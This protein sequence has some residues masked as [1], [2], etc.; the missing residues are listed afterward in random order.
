MTRSRSSAL[1]TL[2]YRLTARISRR[3]QRMRTSASRRCSRTT[4]IPRR[5]WRGSSSCCAS[6]ASSATMTCHLCRP[7][8]PMHVCAW[9]SSVPRPP[10]LC[11]CRTPPPANVGS[12]RR[13]PSS[14]CR[15]WAS[16]THWTRPSAS[17]ATPSSRC[18]R[19]RSRART[20]RLACA[21]R[22]C[23]VPRR[24]A[25]SAAATWRPLRTT[26]SRA[27][28]TSPWWRRPRSSRSRSVR[29]RTR[30]RSAWPGALRRSRR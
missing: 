30:A 11:R 20:R 28:R 8:R 29:R 17:T 3:R 1:S 24:T 15:P 22:A 2:G 14:P 21:P 7:T 12:A 13:R 5:S 4:R 19:A 23:A 16:W 27:R 10:R 18:R 25:P 9:A 26:G 6:S